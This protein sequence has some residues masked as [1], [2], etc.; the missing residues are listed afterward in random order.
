MDIVWLAAGVGFLL[1]TCGL[2][3]CL[4]SLRAED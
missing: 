3:R 4:S 2:I 1:G